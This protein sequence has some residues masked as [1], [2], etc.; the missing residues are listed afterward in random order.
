MT[1]DEEERVSILCLLRDAAKSI[2]MLKQ[3]GNNKRARQLISM[4]IEFLE[5]D[6]TSDSHGG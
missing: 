6:E 2:L 3:T 4:A 1:Q 5:A